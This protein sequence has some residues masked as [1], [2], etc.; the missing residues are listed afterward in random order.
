[1]SE[2]DKIRPYEAD[3]IKEFDNP[4]PGWWV[5]LF[6]GTVIFSV[7]YI[8]YYHFGP[9]TSI[10][11]QLIADRQELKAQQEA[12][13]KEL[14]S[15]PAPGQ[16]NNGAGAVPAQSQEELV[17][18]G[19]TH[20]MTYCMPCHG[21]KG[22]GT[23]GPNL[24]DEYWL[25]GGTTADITKSIAEGIPAKGMAPWLGVLGPKKIAQVVA[26]IESI[27]GTN[28]AGAKAPQGDKVVA[29]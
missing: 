1:M 18:S 11:Q 24:T 16:D 14:T 7:V 19:K 3:G 20:Y 22:Q 13:H 26:F 10:D 21:D 28:P 5:Q 6:W 9:G 12:A 15:N 4:M 29:P 27:Q 23:V 17:A 25:H 2:K 8:G